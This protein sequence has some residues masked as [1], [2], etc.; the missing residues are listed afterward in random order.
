MILSSALM[1]SRFAADF[2]LREREKF[3]FSIFD[4]RRSRLW[5]YWVEW[6]LVLIVRLCSITWRSIWYIICF[7][8]SLSQLCILLRWAIASTEF[9]VT[10]RETGRERAHKA[11]LYISFHR[12]FFRVSSGERYV[13]SKCS[14]HSELYLSFTFL[15]GEL[16]RWT[17][18]LTLSR[19]QFAS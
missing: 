19:S 9:R 2:G 11:T 10:I 3:R 7:D 12:G 8:R 5:S 16:L 6:E 4:L 18:S 15:E 13:G 14:A 1:N 17:R